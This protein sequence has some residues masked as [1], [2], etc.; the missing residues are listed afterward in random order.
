MELNEVLFENGITLNLKGENKEEVFN[1]LVDLLYRNERITS[2]EE[3]LKA[4]YDREAE[5]VTGIGNGIAIPHGLSDCVE[6]PTIVY[7]FHE[8]G[9]DYESMDDIP[10]QMFFMIAVPN[11]SSKEHLSLISKLATK[12]IHEDFIRELKEVKTKKRIL[13]II[14]RK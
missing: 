3:F 7:G 11:N 10:V 2:R 5:G 4:L 12:L 1:E 14:S 8:K 6:K 9:I 13:T